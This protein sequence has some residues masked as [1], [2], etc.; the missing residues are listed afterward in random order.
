MCSRKPRRYLR[1]F[2]GEILSL[3]VVFRDVADRK[4]LEQALRTSEQTYRAIGESIEYGVWV[5]DPDGRNTYASESFL[6]LVGLTQDQCSGFGWG[7]VLHP[8]DAE[9]TIAAWRECVHAKGAWNREHRFRGADGQ[10]HW[11]LA[12]GVPIKDEHGKVICWAGIN[13]DIDQVKASE[14]A[15]RRHERD[16]RAANLELVRAMKI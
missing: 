7:S 16:L 15:L 1:E 13:L 8:D 4:R 2:A 14:E 3:V 5:C 12:R 10:Y 11:I 9:Q 6:K